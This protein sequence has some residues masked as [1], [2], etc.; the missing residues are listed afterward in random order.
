M[1]RSAAGVYGALVRRP[2]LLDL[3]VALGLFAV[4]VVEV[5]GAELAEDVV[6]GP[7]G[8]NVSRSRRRRCR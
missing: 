4:G 2:P 7:T 6:Q 8:L 5:L 1:P 3:A